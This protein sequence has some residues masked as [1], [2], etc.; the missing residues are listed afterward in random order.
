M[1]RGPTPGQVRY[2]LRKMKAKY[3]GSTWQLVQASNGE[4]FLM[5]TDTVNPLPPYGD[6]KGQSCETPTP[7]A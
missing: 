3:P 2:R 1:G 4:A 5:R 6:K 7:R